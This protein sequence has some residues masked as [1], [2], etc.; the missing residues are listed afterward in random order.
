MTRLT[1]GQSFVALNGISGWIAKEQGFFENYGLDVTLTLIRGDTQ[2]VQALL[3][4]SVDFLMVGAVAAMAANAAG[5]DVI[6]LATLGSTIPYI[7]VTVPEIQSPQDLKG[8]RVG[9]SGTGLSVSRAAME[10]AL[11]DFGL[12][13]KRDGIVFLPAGSASER[14][15][16]LTTGGIQATVL[17]M[18]QHPRVAQLESE[19]KLRVLADLS[20]LNISWDHDFILTTG[21]YRNSHPDVIERF[22]KAIVEANAFIL[23]PVNKQAVLQSI[24][25]N[26]KSEELAEEIYAYVPKTVVPR[27]YSSMEAIST[28][29]DV[30]SEDFPSLAK[31]KVERLVDSSFL[32]R[33][34][35]SGFIASL[36]NDSK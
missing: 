12:E 15:V 36:Y 9:V 1:L 25:T 21:A 30:L 27:P 23:S 32:R 31:L 5:A 35:E 13:P 28:V 11:R 16:A 7:L 20:E 33:L 2:G 3:G 10:I 8:K 6:T 22:M 17:S 19:G 14:V 24:A 34:D 4:R 29:A 26:L 18:A